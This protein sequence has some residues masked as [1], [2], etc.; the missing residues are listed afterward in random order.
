MTTTKATLRTMT[1][2]T[3]TMTKTAI[4]TALIKTVIVTTKTTRLLQVARFANP[5]MTSNNVQPI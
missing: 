3:K 2:I 1:A 5:N 4:T